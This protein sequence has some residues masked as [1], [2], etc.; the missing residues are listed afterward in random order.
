MSQNTIE[1]NHFYL[2]PFD[3]KKDFSLSYEMWNDNEILEMMECPPCAKEE[4]KTKLERYQSWM[5]RFSFTN[6]AVFTKDTNDFVGSAG[7][8][9]FHDPDGDRLPITPINSEKYSHSDIELGYVLHK[10]YWGKGYA[11]ELAQACVEFVFH[12]HPDIKRIVAVTVLNNIAS[13]HILSKI[14]FKF[15]TNIISKEYG[16]EKFFVLNRP[17]GRKI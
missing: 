16:K 10:K 9:L 5:D 12:N 14:G 11:T 6:F 8:S 15:I 17:E 1:T 2:R 3:H 13:Q 7:M 4:I